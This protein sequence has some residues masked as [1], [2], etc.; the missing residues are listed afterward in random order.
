LP[1]GQ[2]CA[3]I[4]ANYAFG[5]EMPYICFEAGALLSEIKREL[6][7]RLT[8]VSAEIM[9]IPKDYFFVSIHELPNENVA[10]SGEDVNQI[11]EELAARRSV[12]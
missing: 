3:I 9:G 8:D 11:R 12:E 1:A 4:I 5:I 10:I 7:R 6:I 2:I